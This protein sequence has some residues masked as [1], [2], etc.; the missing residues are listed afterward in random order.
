MQT[1]VFLIKEQVEL[2]RSQVGYKKE[3][4]QPRT[5]HTNYCQ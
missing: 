3:E 2:Q 4:K 1:V 5:K